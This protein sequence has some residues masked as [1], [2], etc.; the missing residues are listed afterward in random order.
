M[1]IDNEACCNLG[2]TPNRERDLALN[3]F[4]KLEFLHADSLRV[5]N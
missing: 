4:L 5:A 3:F 2:A 1:R